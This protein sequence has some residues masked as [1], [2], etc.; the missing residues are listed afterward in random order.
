MRGEMPKSKVSELLTSMPSPVVEA[1]FRYEH[2]G[3]AP[4]EFSFRVRLATINETEEWRQY[5]RAALVSSEGLL[6]PVGDWPPI[7]WCDWGHTD[8]DRWHALL[9][10][11]HRR[12][13][14]AVSPGPG[15]KIRRNLSTPEARAFWE[16]VEKSA[17][18]IRDEPAWKKVW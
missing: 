4:V 16:G 7:P 2:R 3:G 14:A 9:V 1:V 12:L 10:D 15:P 11:L 18:L 8:Y 17:A 6:I 5:K 13:S